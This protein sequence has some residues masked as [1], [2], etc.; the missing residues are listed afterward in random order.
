MTSPTETFPLVHSYSP[1]DEASA[2]IQ[3]RRRWTKLGVS[4]IVACAAIVGVVNY[5]QHARYDAARAQAD[6]MFAGMLADEKAFYFPMD[7][8]A[9][10]ASSSSS[11]NSN[12]RYLRALAATTAGGEDS[13]WSYKWTNG[14]DSK[15]DFAAIGEYYHAKGL[16]IADFYRSKFDPTYKNSGPQT[17]WTPDWQADKERGIAIGQKYA[18]IGQNIADHYRQ[19]FD[20]TYV[21]DADDEED[22]EN[23]GRRMLKSKAKK[24]KEEKKKKRDMAFYDWQADRDR[25][26]AIGQ[27]FR[28][29]GLEI[30]SH[31]A[32]HDVPSTEWQ[33]QRV[34]GL[35]IAQRYKDKAAAIKQFYETK[36]MPVAPQAPSTASSLTQDV[37]QSPYV[38]GLNQNEDRKHAFDMRKTWITRGKSIGNYY[39]SVY[40]PTYGKDEKTLDQKLAMSGSQAVV[41]N[42][43]LE[44]PPWGQDPEAD[45]AHG[46][47]LGEY[48]AQKGQEAGKY[49]EK[50]GSELHEYYE[51]KY[52]TMFDPTYKVTDP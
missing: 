21:T 19:A 49:W 11:N 38:W 34:E 47:A 10:T 48:W 17:P 24:E 6:Q 44:F 14:L 16:G 33:K 22:E 32:G 2:N 4:T 37:S 26:I 50:K 31:Y 20:P 45:R 52:R 35:A 41:R 27:Q 8:S 36:Y 28:D 1:V 43:D 13:T 51:D 9:I 39:R 29:I 46:S 18:A 5:V 42:P 3:T 23:N 12:H 25:G 7:P 40:D 15:K 30:A